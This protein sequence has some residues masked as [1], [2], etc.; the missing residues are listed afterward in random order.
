MDHV[1]LLAGSVPQTPHTLG[2]DCRVTIDLAAEC[3]HRGDG[4]ETQND[5]RVVWWFPLSEL[6]DCVVGLRIVAGLFKAS[7]PLGA[8]NQPLVVRFDWESGKQ[9]KS[10]F[11]DIKGI[12][13]RA[14]L[15]PSDW[16]VAAAG[17]SGGGFLLFWKPDDEKPSVSF[18][19][20]NIARG[21]D[22]S[23]D[24]RTIATAHH[25]RKLRITKV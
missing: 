6:V 11:S 14:F 24:L 9:L 16:L 23:P 5:F 1:D 3:T 21:M 17:G 2:V 10:H 12:A 7:N 15:H 22:I 19:L 18:K 8:V 13:W 20:P 4:H 25:D